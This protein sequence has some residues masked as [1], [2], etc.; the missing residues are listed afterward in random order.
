M[1]ILHFRSNFDVGLGYDTLAMPLEQLKQGHEV[2]VLTTDRAS[3]SNVGK[4][5]LT[6]KDAA[7]LQAPSFEIKGLK[8]YRLPTS[9]FHYD[10]VV[11]PKGA[12]NFLEKFK[13][14]IVQTMS[15][16]EML[17]L[18][19]A[20]NKARL[21]YRLFTREDQ[22]DFPASTPLRRFIITAEYL[23]WRRFWCDYV[24]NRCDMIFAT[25]LPGMEFLRRYHQIKSGIPI[26]Y[27]P[28]VVD[29]S[30]FHPDPLA[31][32]RVR[33]KMGVD[34]SEKVLINAG[35]VVPLKRFEFLIEAMALV[36]KHHA[37]QAWIIGGGDAA[38]I[39]S[40][41]MLAEKKGCKD[42]IRFLPNIS[43]FNLPGYFNAADMG[44][45]NRSTSSIQEAMC[46]GLPVIMSSYAGMIL[47]EYK[48]GVILGRDP[49]MRG[50]PK[51]LAAEIATMATDRTYAKSI[52]AR[53]L[54]VAKSRLNI[55]VQTKELIGLYEAALK[56]NM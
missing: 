7:L 14:D 31:R 12:V 42:C 44:F 4:G 39:Q 55:T 38:Y 37:V 34:P 23:A 24:F 54:K 52:A 47:E 46:C 9:W 43:H 2:V 25:S 56:K 50:G 18:T 15:A 27:M 28:V 16:K 36:P 41:K 35:K 32:K 22:Y 53:C 21:G 26:K 13:P 30:A 49:T 11:I 17:P 33:K 48:A 20:K 1:K 19:A 5:T 45:W 8:V 40:L 29:T 3:S 10:D 51:E 6:Q